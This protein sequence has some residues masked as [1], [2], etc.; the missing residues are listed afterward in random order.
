[1]TWF[2][3][4]GIPQS[5]LNLPTVSSASGSIATFDTDL[6]D[7]LIK[8]VADIAVDSVGFSSV[9]IAKIIPLNLVNDSLRVY[10]RW[11]NPTTLKWAGSSA[12]QCIA[13]A[14]EPNTTYAIGG[15]LTTG[16]NYRFAT[17]RVSELPTDNATQIDIYQL[18]TFATNEGLGQ[19][20]IFTTDADATY[21]VIQL[22]NPLMSDFMDNGFVYKASSNINIALGETLTQGGSL[23]VLSGVLTRTDTTTKQLSSN[24]IATILGQNNIL[25]DTGDIDVEFLE[26]VGHKIGG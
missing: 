24:Q 25:A 22:R 10:D 9:N 16:V 20:H 12:N 2:R 21:L 8:C 14:V 7:N 5:V 26:T 11:L 1:M 17:I 19:I 3:C 18:E 13:I 4:G 6:T 23:D 15:Y